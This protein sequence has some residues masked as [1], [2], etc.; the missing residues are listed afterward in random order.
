LGE[1]KFK[2]T[3]YRNVDYVYF[4]WMFGDD[5]DIGTQHQLKSSHFDDKA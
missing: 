5:T 4:Y 1:E 3:R 2:L